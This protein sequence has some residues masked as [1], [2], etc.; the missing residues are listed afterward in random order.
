MA[1]RRGRHNPLEP[2]NE[3]RWVVVRDACNRPVRYR[4]LSPRAD[5]RAALASE[6]DRMLA[7]GWVTDEIR[8][9]AFVFC[10]KGND[11]WCIS[12]ECYEPGTSPP[13]P[14]TRLGDKLSNR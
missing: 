13:G 6:R 2:A 11:R 3:L 4:M 9:Y 7:E 5:L 8:W 12:V 1:N 14:G 10:Q